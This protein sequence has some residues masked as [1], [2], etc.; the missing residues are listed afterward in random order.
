MN[1][2]LWRQESSR[3]LSVPDADCVRAGS[4]QMSSQQHDKGPVFKPECVTL[5]SSEQIAERWRSAREGENVLF[6]V[7][8]T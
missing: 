1:G 2:G 8:R 5:L 4:E 3:N 6:T 7:G